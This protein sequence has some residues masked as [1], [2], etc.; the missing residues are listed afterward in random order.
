MLFVDALSEAL[1]GLSLMELSALAYH[2]LV[3]AHFFVDRAVIDGNSQGI[4]IAS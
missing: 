1:H 4:S 3:A 2:I